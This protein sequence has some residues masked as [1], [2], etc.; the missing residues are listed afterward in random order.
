MSYHNIYFFDNI[1]FDMRE[2]LEMYFK[3]KY[4]YFSNFENIHKIISNYNNINE[5]YNIIPIFGVNDRKS[6]FV[7]DF[8]NF[9]DTDYTFLY[10]YLS[11]VKKYIL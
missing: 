10:N 2:S 6:P 1:K 7:L 8:Y 11:F 3:N 5:F 9:I 4:N